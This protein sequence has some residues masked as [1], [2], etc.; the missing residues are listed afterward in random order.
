MAISQLAPPSATAEQAVLVALPLVLGGLLLWGRA[1]LAEVKD[2]HQEGQIQLPTTEE[3]RGRAARGPRSGSSPAAGGSRHDGLTALRLPRSPECLPSGPDLALALFPAHRAPLSSLLPP[4]RPRPVAPGRVR[5]GPARIRAG[6]CPGRLVPRR[7][8]L[9]LERVGDPGRQRAGGQEGG[10]SAQG[11]HSRRHPRR[12]CSA[13][14]QAL[15]FRCVAVI[16]L[17]ISSAALAS[18][19]ARLASVPADTR[20]CPAL[21]VP[22]TVSAHR[23]PTPLVLVLPTLRSLALSLLLAA[24][25]FPRLFCRPAPPLPAQGAPT[26]AEPDDP[27][28]NAD[29]KDQLTLWPVFLRR[30][31]ELS[32]YLWPSDSARLQAASVACVLLMILGRASLRL[33]LPVVHLPKLIPNLDGSLACQV[34]ATS[35]S[36]SRSGPSSTTCRP[37]AVRPLLLVTTLLPSL[38]APLPCPPSHQRQRGH[39]PSTSRCRCSHPRSA[40]SST[41]CTTCCGFLVRWPSPANAPSQRPR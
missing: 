40:A 3:V 13:G 10:R 15:A 31:A 28:E 38:T 39:S 29:D 37:A 9:G 8:R 22:V 17:P 16:S 1:A 36:R 21:S 2:G 14:L 35:G 6:I 33:P 41:S 25:V 19:A 32:P 30:L 24:L 12:G 23:P 7:R 26:S 4:R 34:S 20:S 5:R 27:K 11:G 18:L